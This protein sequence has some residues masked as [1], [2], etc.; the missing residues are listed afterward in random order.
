MLSRLLARAGGGEEPRPGTV[1]DRI[2]QVGRELDGSA[3]QYG[4]MPPGALR[5]TPTGTELLAEPPEAL[6]DLAVIGLRE[7]ARIRQLPHVDFNSPAGRERY[8]WMTAAEQLAAQALRR[9]LPWTEARLGDLLDA[10]ID[11]ARRRY[12][13]ED[14][15]WLTAETD[16][17]KPV[18][19]TVER[20]AQDGA[21]PAGLHGRLRRVAELLGSEYAEDRKAVRRIEALTGGAAELRPSEDPW[22]LALLATRESL[23]AARMQVADRVLALAVTATGARPTKTFTAARAKLLSGR[24]RAAA[25]EV[26]VALLRAAAIPGGRDAGQVPG[27]VGDALRGLSWIAGAVGGEP[28]AAALGDLAIV[29]WRK[30]PSHGP[31][32]SKAANAALTALGEF[33]EGARSS[34]ASAR[35]SNSPPRSAP[36]TQP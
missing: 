26:T 11:S 5:A 25:G 34:A 19:L 32:C 4:Y 33:P 31:L 8:L 1:E 10:V 35:S 15:P 2:R 20:S 7:L 14:K 6:I 27:D 22:T 36:S 13:Y 21:A 29:G 18:V 23:S 12:G 17:V 16:L 30:V 9:K 24:G 3:G 28:A